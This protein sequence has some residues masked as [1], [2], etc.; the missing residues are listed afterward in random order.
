MSSSHHSLNRLFVRIGVTTCLFVVLFLVN[1]GRVEAEWS[2]SKN[3]S[4]WYPDW[5][6]CA[7]KN[8]TAT[9]IHSWKRVTKYCNITTNINLCFAGGQY[10][11]NYCHNGRNL[12]M[13]VSSSFDEDVDSTNYVLKLVDAVSQRDGSIY[14]DG[15]SQM[16]NFRL[17][18]YCDLYRHNLQKLDWNRELQPFEY[19]GH[20]IGFS[21]SVKTD[22]DVSY[23]ATGAMEHI[24]HHVAS[25]FESGYKYLLVVIGLGTHYNAVKRGRD[26]DRDDYRKRLELM[27][28]FWNSIPGLFPNN[29]IDIVFSETPPQHWDSPNGYWGHKKTKCVPVSRPDPVLDWR[30]GELREAIRRLGLPH[31]HVMSTRYL[32]NLHSE[33]CN[34]DFYDCTHYA[35]WPMLYQPMY[36]QLYQIVSANSED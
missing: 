30:N 5:E 36:R 23:N 32:L 9:D 1:S 2:L 19:N 12:S 11:H 25:R 24:I 17:G 22:N 27:L 3:L 31:L 33:H 15:D 26:G 10:Q 4:M 7:I 28:P 20:K 14:F 16:T 21:G 29:S 35:Y 34:G 13:F 6:I 8:N 18:V